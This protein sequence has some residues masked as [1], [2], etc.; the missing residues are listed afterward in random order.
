MN[1]R[2]KL[3]LSIILI[4]MLGIFMLNFIGVRADSGFD[5][6]YDR[7]GSDYSGG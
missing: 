3:M 2:N 1:N 7:G 6:D 5:V 4:G